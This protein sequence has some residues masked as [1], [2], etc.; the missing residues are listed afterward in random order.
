MFLEYSILFVES[1]CIC[2]LNDLPCVRKVQI[3]YDN[4][5]HK[6]KLGDDE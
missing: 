6:G 2:F 4:D 3:R 1:D 5:Q